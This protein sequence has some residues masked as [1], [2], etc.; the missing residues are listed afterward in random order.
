MVVVIVIN[1]YFI[2]DDVD[3]VVGFAIV[4]VICDAVVSFAGCCHGFV[5]VRRENVIKRII[6][7]L[8]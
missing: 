8:Q 7:I 1:Y 5:V 2:G 3:V 6:N 4:F